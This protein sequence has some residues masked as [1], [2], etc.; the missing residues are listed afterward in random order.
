MSIRLE[1][2]GSGDCGRLAKALGGAQSTPEIVESAIARCGGNPLFTEEFV[3]YAI[4]RRVDDPDGRPSRE[5]ATII[6][7]S[8]MSLISARLDALPSAERRLICDA[9]VVGQVFWPGALAAVRD[10]DADQARDSELEELGRRGLITALPSSSVACETEFVFAHGLIRDVAYSRLTRLARATRHAAIANWIGGA[11]EA[12]THLVGVRA[13]HAVTALELARAAHDEDLAGRLHGPAA[14]ALDEAGRVALAYDVSSAQDYFARAVEL[15]EGSPELPRLLVSWSETLMLCGRHAE[16][17]VNLERA[18]D[19]ADA[20]ADGALRAR[21]LVARATSARFVGRDS[22][23]MLDEALKLAIRTPPSPTMVDVLVQCGREV[24]AG[25]SEPSEYPRAI[26]ILEQALDAATALALPPPPM[27]LTLTGYLASRRGDIH[28]RRMCEEAV[29]EAHSQGL[30]SVSAYCELGLAE[31]VLMED[32]PRQA[33]RLFDEAERTAERHGERETRVGATLKRT[34]CLCL[35]GL[36]DEAAD[37]AI[38]LV[39]QLG[40]SADVFDLVEATAMLV[41][42]RGRRG[43]IDAGTPEAAWLLGHCEAPPTSVGLPAFIAPA[44]LLAREGEALRARQLISSWLAAG[45]PDVTGQV[46][47][48]CE[49]ARIA[50]SAGAPDLARLELDGLTMGWPIV[51]HSGHSIRALLAADEGDHEKAARLY[52]DAV[53][54]WRAF[55]APYEQAHALVG[56][57]CAEAALGDVRGARVVI[58][59]GMSIF[60]SLKA[61]PDAEAALGCL[62]RLGPQA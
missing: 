35:A 13:H 54:R 9:A 32:G 21:G 47:H 56:L 53:Q 37:D 5:T 38:D 39:T 48:I 58:T 4:E 60:E 17:D 44:A 16:A 61:R 57:G 8:L 26:A 11:A 6:P 34:L 25:L 41:L 15:A 49:A 3:R 52:L 24:I 46:E 55:G 29:R 30:G 31:V 27:A 23:P 28:G 7:E 18:L 2:L 1:A 14:A 51:Q 12:R 20:A 45:P 36:W 19:L 62:E 59:E 10:D 50:V 40:D 42:I 22:R 43:E 33:L